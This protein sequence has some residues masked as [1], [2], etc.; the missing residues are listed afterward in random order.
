MEMEEKKLLEL[1]TAF[2]R[3]QDQKMLVNHFTSGYSS[4]IFTLFV[5]LAMCNIGSPSRAYYYGTN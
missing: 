5:L 2:S 1:F 4:S 3:D